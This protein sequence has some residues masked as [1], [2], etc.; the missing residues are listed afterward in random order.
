MRAHAR[1]FALCLILCLAGPAAAG[2]DGFVPRPHG[3][4]PADGRNHAQPRVRA[5]RVE[6]GAVRLDGRLDEAA[7]DRAPAA[8]GFRQFDPER[9]APALVETVFKVLYDEE[10]VY[11]GLA[12]WDD[13]DRISSALGRRDDIR[14]SDIISLYIDPYH[15]R[16]TGYN[17]RVNALGVLADAAMSDDGHRNFT[18]DAVWDAQVHVDERGWYAELRVP[19]AAI[20]YTPGDERTWGLQVYRWLHGRGQDTAWACWDRDLDGFT[21]RFGLLEGMNDLVAARQLEV[22]PYVVGSLTDAAVPGDEP[23]EHFGNFGADVRYGVTADLTLNATIQPD[24]GQVEADPSVLNLSPFETSFSEK[25]PFFIEGA[26]RFEQPEF[27]LFYSRR[28]GTGQENARIRFASKLTGRTRRGWTVAALAAAT[29]VTDPGKAHIPWRDGTDGTLYG[30]LR[31]GREN[32]DGTRSWHVMGTLVDRDDTATATVDAARRRDAGTLGADFEL[33]LFDRC[34]QLRGSLVRTAMRPHFAGA[35]AGA[36]RGTKLGSGGA[37]EIEETKGDWIGSLRTAWESDGLDPNDLGLLFAPDEKNVSGWLRWRYDA[38]AGGG[39][40]NHANID[41]RLERSWFYAGSDRL[42]D[43]GAPLWRYGAGTPQNL[44]GNVGA[45][46]QTRNFWQLYAGV[47][48][49]RPGLSKYA[50]RDFDGRRGPLYATPAITGQWI[51]FDTDRRKPFQLGF[52]LNHNG[53]REG[54]RGWDLDLW[55]RWQVGDRFNL[56]LSGGYESDRAIAQWVDNFAAAP[57][58]G[59]GGVDYVFARL[60]RRTWDLTWRSSWLFSRDSSLE[61]YVQP[62]LTV[63]DYTDPRTLDAPGA[64]ADTPYAAPGFDVSDRDFRYAAVNLNLVWRWQYRPGSTLFLVWTH[65]REDYAA[66]RDYTDR[67][68]FGNRFDTGH[69]FGGEPGN[70]VMVK[71]TYWL[72]VL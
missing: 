29:D 59:I 19:L 40:V 26:S 24:F 65:A 15:D 36:E 10:A 14:N 70:R 64:A 47:W 71:L 28:I 13:P 62:F 48:H 16:T 38:D 27:S 52:E 51:G 4:D 67:S 33:R 46:C 32:A 25:R 54:E 50:T 43:D 1:C 72:S 42:A 9:G 21:S 55:G 20:R 63:G 35:Y 22:T 56:S 41:A 5:A 58:A 23:P 37:L 53:N 61:L 3:D 8:Y 39:L 17:F 7:W 30:L 69:L 60:D 44:S 11:F 45:W 34:W 68:R 18:W 12:C 49:D 31:L 57:G 6:N 2:L 66:R